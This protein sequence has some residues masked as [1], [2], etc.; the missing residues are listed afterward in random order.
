MPRAPPRRGGQEEG[1]GRHELERAPLCRACAMC[2][3]DTILWDPHLT[4]WSRQGAP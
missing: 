3:T 4:L 1:Q 2:V